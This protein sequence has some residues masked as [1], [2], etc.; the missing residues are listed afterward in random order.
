MERYASLADMLVSGGDI[1][2]GALPVLHLAQRKGLIS[3]LR[4]SP[5][6]DPQRPA[7]RTCSFGG[8]IPAFMGA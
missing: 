2:D 8:N 1:N 4:F 5:A 7:P 6:N 3:R